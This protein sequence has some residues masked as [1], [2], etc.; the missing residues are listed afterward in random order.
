MHKRT[1]GF[2]LI[3][4]LVVVLIIGVLSAIA[5]PQYPKTVAKSRAAQLYTAINGL[6]KAVQSYFLANGSWPENFDGLDLDFPLPSQQGTA[7]D[8]SVGT[9]NTLK[10]G[11]DYALV[12]GKSTLWNDLFA[13][14]T[15]GPYPCAGFAY[16][17]SEISSGDELFCV[18]R[19]SRTNYAK[20]DFCTKVMGFTFERN[21]HGYDYFR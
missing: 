11:K 13:V 12:I 4:L 5:L 2:T 16:I 9:G 21:Y 6:N 19:D 7:C 18:E 17:K 15:Q 1:D 8:L 10:L 3:E 14:F 20:G